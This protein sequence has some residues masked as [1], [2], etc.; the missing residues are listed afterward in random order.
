M[1]LKK[2]DYNKRFFNFLKESSGVANKIQV[3]F[4]NI[5]L[6]FKIIFKQISEN[7]FNLLKCFY[8]QFVVVE[9]GK[10]EIKVEIKRKIKLIF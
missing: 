10:V 9:R 3:N 1:V 7:S 6:F 4:L 8:H 2:L 5:I